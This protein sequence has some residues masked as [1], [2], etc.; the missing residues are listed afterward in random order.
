MEWIYWFGTQTRG[1]WSSKFLQSFHT[2]QQA[3]V[4]VTRSTVV[5]ELVCSVRFLLR[6]WLK[7]ALGISVFLAYCCVRTYV[8]SM[9]Y[10]FVHFTEHMSPGLQIYIYHMMHFAY[11]TWQTSCILYI[12]RKRGGGLGWDL[13]LHHVY[14]LTLIHNRSHPKCE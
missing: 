1:N 9:Q 3:A 10:L 8:H 4:A 5:K 12:R 11:I 2:C 6:V 13:I 14:L 7:N